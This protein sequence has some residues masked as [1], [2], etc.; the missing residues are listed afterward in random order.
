[1]RFCAWGK[2]FV[3]KLLYTRGFVSIYCFKVQSCCE[4]FLRPVLRK[5][6]SSYCLTIS[7]N[8]SKSYVFR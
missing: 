1:M 3:S 5:V 8:G 6:V 7:A 2:E 4:T